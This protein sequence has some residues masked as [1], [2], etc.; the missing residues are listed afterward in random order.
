M[1]EFAIP[2]VQPNLFAVVKLI[3]ICCPSC[4]ALPIKSRGIKINGYYFKQSTEIADF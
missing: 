2:L 4:P 3:E 1:H